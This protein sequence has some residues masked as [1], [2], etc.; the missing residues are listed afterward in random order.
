MTAL[1]F[2][3]D[4]TLKLAVHLYERDTDQVVAWMQ[5]HIFG[6]RDMAALM[7]FLARAI[8]KIWPMG[9]TKGVTP[10]E[11]AMWGLHIGRGAT[12]AQ[13]AAGRMMAAAF[14][15]DW[16][17]VDAHIRAVIGSTEAFHAAVAVSL[18]SALGDG[19][20]VAARFEGQDDGE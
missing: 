7:H 18:L 5:A 8:Y 9:I 1:G 2:T 17:M 20:R 11:G 3:N 14:N 10:G 6:P 15:A 4:D 13:A 12:E 19:L 16:P